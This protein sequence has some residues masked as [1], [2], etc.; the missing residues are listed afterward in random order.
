M[1]GLEGCK[2]RFHLVEA[3]VDHRSRIGDLQ[4][5]PV[6]ILNQAGHLG[7]GL[8][9]LAHRCLGLGACIHSAL[10]PLDHLRRLRGQV[11]DRPRDFVRRL[12]RFESERLYL[13]GHH[14]EGSTRLPGARRLDRCIEGE[15]V[16][17][18]GD[19]FDVER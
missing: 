13:I 1:S 8:L 17:R 16:G 15:N 18:L 5:L 10:Y 11:F 12:P 6:D 2:C 9:D 3:R 19:L 14:S 4:V 7:K